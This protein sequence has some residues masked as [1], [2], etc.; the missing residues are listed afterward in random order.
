M[1]IKGM[2]SSEGGQVLSIAPGRHGNA[3]YFKCHTA[4]AYVCVL[5]INLLKWFYM[6]ERERRSESRRAAC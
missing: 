4:F 5:R 2:Q 3:V 1:E 6:R